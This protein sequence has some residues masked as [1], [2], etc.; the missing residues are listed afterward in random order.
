MWGCYC[1]T[2]GLRIYLREQ[3]LSDMR[4]L[5]RSLSPM[6]MA[7]RTAT[8]VVCDGGVHVNNILR[9]VCEDV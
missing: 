5:W 9:E 3:A 7:A 1:I 4:A 6:S 2:W 8:L